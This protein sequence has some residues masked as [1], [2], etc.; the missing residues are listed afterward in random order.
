VKKS[1]RGRE[2]KGRESHVHQR[3]KERKNGGEDYLLP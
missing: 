2:G 1:K 3:K